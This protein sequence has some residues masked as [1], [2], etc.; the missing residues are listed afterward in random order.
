M[1]LS[2][3]S[4]LGQSVA[5][6]A[7]QYQQFQDT[8]QLDAA[9][10]DLQVQAA[11]RIAENNIAL[12]NREQAQTGG[13]VQQAMANYTPAAGEDPDDTAR[14]QALAAAVALNSA[15]KIQEASTL[16]SQQAQQDQHDLA[17]QAL[18]RPMVAGGGYGMPSYV[19]GDDGT[20]SPLGGAAATSARAGAQAAALQV[21]I[22][23][24][25]K[26]ATP[27]IND[28][29]G[30]ITHPFP[31]PS[32]DQSTTPDNKA[33]RD[34]VQTVAKTTIGEALAQNKT[35]D[36]TDL[37]T[38]LVLPKAQAFDAAIQA[39][40]Q[41]QTL[42]AFGPTKN[43]LAADD[44]T[45]PNPTMPDNVKV[46]LSKMVPAQYLQSP[47]AYERYLYDRQMN[48]NNFVQWLAGKNQSSGASAAPGGG[49]PMAAPI[50]PDFAPSGPRPAVNPKAPPI[51]VAPTTAV[52]P[53]APASSID[54]GQPSSAPSAQYVYGSNF[55]PEQKRLVDMVKGIRDNIASHPNGWLIQ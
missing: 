53:A 20:W 38:N 51:P 49:S 13:I 42:A 19:L 15:G 39:K 45:T 21:K 22:T 8:S 11:Q 55:T 43:T 1:L 50:G 36:P 30:P 24:A 18:S 46:A 26:A 31:V 34:T 47:Q 12:Q 35:A 14:N 44:P 16:L 2:A 23:S 25:Q 10:S 5:Q 27:E 33:F 40:V 48:P 54:F 52:A 6:S 37:V 4:G 9:R 32:I 17:Q 3:L 28:A 29:I 7:Q 41:A